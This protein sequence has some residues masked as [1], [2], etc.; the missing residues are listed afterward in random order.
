MLS[1]RHP[2]QEA[3]EHFRD[4]LNEQLTLQIFPDAQL[5][6]AQQMMEGLQFGHI[7]M[8]ILPLESLSR[9]VA[10]LG[11]L[12]LPYLFKNDNHRSQVLDGPLGK[13]FLS[14]LDELNLVGLGF[15]ESCPRFFVTKEQPFSTLEAFQDRRIALVCPFSEIECQ[16]RLYEGAF[17]L[18][19]LIGA[20]PSIIPFTKLQEFLETETVDAIEYP[21]FF[22]IE[23]VFRGGD[24]KTLTPAAH[25]TL[26]TILVAS[27]RWFES[28]APETRETILR[29]SNTLVRQQQQIMQGVRQNI[30]ETLQAQG[31]RIAMQE[32]GD[33]YEATQAFYNT[34]AQEFGPE[35]TQFLQAIQKIARVEE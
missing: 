3:L 19:E 35:F 7:E 1:A 14:S 31:M 16:G 29:A 20:R 5:G 10:E 32:D 18:L 27:K 25:R 8:G 28:L 26:P 23:D 34:H 6:S 13:R 15:L 2:V 22:G 30:Y 9:S 24:F 12:E 21:P 17:H 11:M 33:L 4:S